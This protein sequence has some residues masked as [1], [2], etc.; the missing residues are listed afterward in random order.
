M[1]KLIFK[2]ISL[3]T[4]ILAGLLADAIFKRVWRLA[5]HQDETPQATDAQRSWTEVLAAAALQGAVFALVRAAVDR[6]AAE[7]TR[8]LT[9]SWPGDEDGQPAREQEHAA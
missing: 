3:G 9:G 5:A 7:G 4:S 8:K 2:P 6:A 1:N